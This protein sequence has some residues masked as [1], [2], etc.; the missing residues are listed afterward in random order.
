M[1]V[2]ITW[3][4]FTSVKRELRRGILSMLETHIVMSSLSFRLVLTLVLHPALLLMLC[5]SYLIDLIVAH[6]VL[7]YKRAALC[8]DVLVMAHVLIVVVISRVGLVFLLKGLTL[9]LS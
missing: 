5:L 6:M 4:S 1:A 8:L 7:V 2:L 9:T 3:M